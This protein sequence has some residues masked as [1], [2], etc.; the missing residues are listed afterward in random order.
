MGHDLGSKRSARM[1]RP[2]SPSR[3]ASRRAPEP[4]STPTDNDFIDVKRAMP[5]HVLSTTSTRRSIRPSASS[6]AMTGAG[7]D[8]DDETVKTRESKPRAAPEAA[9]PKR[10]PLY[11]VILMNDDYTPREFVT[12]ILKK[13][14]GLDGDTAHTIMMHAHRSG[15]AR[16]GAWQKD[17]A[18]SKMHNAEEEAHEEGHPLRFRCHPIDD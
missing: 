16:I 7:A 6:L 15:E 17:I 2:N 5:E 8:G 9:K 11:A 12:Q 14:F 18:E 13:H 4:G 10:P 3:I 1:V